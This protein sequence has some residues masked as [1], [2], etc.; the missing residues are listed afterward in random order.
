MRQGVGKEGKRREAIDTR[1]L[2]DVGAL[3]E[4]PHLGKMLAESPGSG[5]NPVEVAAAQEE[6][7]P[8]FRAAH[9]RG[10]AWIARQQGDSLARQPV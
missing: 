2:N 1:F 6:I 4:K 5:S 7:L 8:E 3:G 10:A 9:E